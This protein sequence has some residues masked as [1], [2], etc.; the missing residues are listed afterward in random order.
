MALPAS[1]HVGKVKAAPSSAGRSPASARSAASPI[2]QPDA[3][4]R[5]SLAR[6]AVRGTFFANRAKPPCR[7]APV[8]SH[9]GRHE[10]EP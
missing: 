7:S 1:A 2:G 5:A 9:V 3:L 10:R 4:R 6:P 8:N